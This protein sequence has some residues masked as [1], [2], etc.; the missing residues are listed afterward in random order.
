MRN[1]EAVLVLPKAAFF[2]LLPIFASWSEIMSC[3][4]ALTIPPL[5]QTQAIILVRI[6]KQ[7]LWGHHQLGELLLLLPCY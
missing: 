7:E 6:S 3:L 4:I 5:L 2:F 1:T